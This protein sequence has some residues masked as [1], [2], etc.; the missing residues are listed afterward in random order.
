MPLLILWSVERPSLLIPTEKKSA[1]TGCPRVVGSTLPPVISNVNSNPIFAVFGILPNALPNALLI[2]VPLAT[3]ADVTLRLIK[4]CSD[5]E[6]A[7]ENAA[8]VLNPL[9]T[10]RFARLFPVVYTRYV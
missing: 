4:S 8:A 7:S 9:P 10:L 3:S 5:V 1:T 6:L 2:A